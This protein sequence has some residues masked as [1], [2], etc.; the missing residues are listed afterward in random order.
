MN[1]IN[2]ASLL[3]GVEARK[4]AVLYLVFQAASEARKDVLYSAFNADIWALNP[5]SELRK[6]VVLAL[7]LFFNADIWALNPASEARKDVL[8]SDF[9]AEI[10]DFNPASELR[11]EVDS[12]FNA[13]IWALNPASEA[14]KDVL[15]SDFNAE[16][17]VLY[18]DFNAAF[19]TE[20]SPSYV[21]FHDFSNAATLALYLFL[22]NAMLSA[23]FV[24]LMFRWFSSSWT[25]FSSCVSLLFF[26]FLTALFPARF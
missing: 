20:V 2:F 3:D 25:Y 5:A 9:N 15:Y 10:L 14:R 11:K 18:L 23:I 4:A 6:E 16:I 13:D 19:N 22:V 7:Y 12:D 17:S 8:Y 24:A 21:D 26:V 1:S